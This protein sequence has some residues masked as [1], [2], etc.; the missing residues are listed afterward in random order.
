MVDLSA[1]ELSTIRTLS[2]LASGAPR[3]RQEAIERCDAIDVVTE[4]LREHYRDGSCTVVVYFSGVPEDVFDEQDGRRTFAGMKR[5]V[6]APG[7]EVEW[8]L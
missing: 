1:Q 4:L 3:E 5:D 2:R 6:L 8:S 7:L